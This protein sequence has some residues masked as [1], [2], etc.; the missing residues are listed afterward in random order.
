MRWQMKAALLAV[1]A[2]STAACPFAALAGEGD[3]V[4]TVFRVLVGSPAAA[5]AGGASVLT[6]PG[7][8]VMLG[9]SPEEEAKDILDLM[10]KLKDSYRLGDVSLAASSAKMLTAGVEVEVPAFDRDLRIRATLLAFNA[11][12]ATYG[13]SISEGG[14]VVSEPKVTMNRGMRGIVG[15]RDGAAA[16]Y[17][18]LVV[19]PLRSAT[20]AHVSGQGASEIAPPKLLGRVTP[21]YPE[22]A[23]KARLAGVVLLDCEIGPDGA[24]RRVTPVR[25]EPMGLTEAAAAAVRQWRYEPP[26]DAA[27]KA[28]SAEITVTVAFQLQ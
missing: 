27:G 20:P 10:G 11:T 26:R 1:A 8:V 23:R 24:V 7:P 3:G 17:F 16:P 15:S 28:V 12:Q 9:K 25:E 19:E 13:V 4:F 2:V 22:A 5:E 21:A 18:F 6:V 14:K